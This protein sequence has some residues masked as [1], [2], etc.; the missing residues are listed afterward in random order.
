MLKDFSQEFARRVDKDE[1]NIGGMFIETQ[2]ISMK[3]ILPTDEVSG[4][5][6]STVIINILL[7]KACKRH[8]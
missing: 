1:S 8:E 5:W 7:M 2:M 6:H 4:L 3:K